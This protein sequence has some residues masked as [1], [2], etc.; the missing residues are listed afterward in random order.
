MQ[1]SFVWENLKK[2]AASLPVYC[3]PLS[4]WGAIFYVNICLKKQTNRDLSMRYNNLSRQ[5]HLS[6]KLKQ[7]AALN[8]VGCN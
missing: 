2:G 5:F 7:I 6:L 4:Q 8:C 1:V 3:F